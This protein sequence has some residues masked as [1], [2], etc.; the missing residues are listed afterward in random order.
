[1]AMVGTGIFHSPPLRWGQGCG[2]GHA[3]GAGAWLRFWQQW[4]CGLYTCSGRVLAMAEAVGGVVG[5]AQST[6]EKEFPK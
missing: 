1:M 6:A 3:G 2:C 4:G 5:A